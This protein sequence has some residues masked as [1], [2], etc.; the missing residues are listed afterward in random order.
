MTN[1]RQSTGPRG[2]PGARRRDNVRQRLMDA[3]RR[4]FARQDFAAVTVRRLAAEAG[5]N[6][7]MVHYYFGDK[8]G[9]YEATLEAAVEPFL[10]QLEQ[11]AQTADP[12]PGAV[13]TV[14][15]AYVETLGR[16]PWLPRL[17]IR[18]VLAH[19]GPFRSRFTERFARRA[20][21]LLARTMRSDQLAEH[22]RADL[23]PQLAALSLVSLAAFPFIAL[24]V[25]REA[26]G[27]RSGP[28]FR[29]QLVAHTEQLFLH[30]VSR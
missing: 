18:E 25:T 29:R 24:P 14:L 20:A 7:A 30:G 27:V 3:A 17:I 23:D 5:V 6:P 1:H 10:V 2:R 21:G 4:L 9:L 28:A 11:L 8:Q 13:R 16:N 15:A 12:G 19:E 22:F 26:F